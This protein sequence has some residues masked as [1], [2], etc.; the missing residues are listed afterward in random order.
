MQLDQLASLQLAMA[1]ADVVAPVEVNI[2]FTS[3]LLVD[4]N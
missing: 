1:M 3:M 2:S 4:I